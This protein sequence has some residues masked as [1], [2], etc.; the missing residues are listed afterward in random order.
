MKLSQNR[1]RN[2]VLGILLA[3]AGYGLCAC[4][5]GTI[6]PSDLPDGGAV[7]LPR[8]DAGVAR[9]QIP[10]PTGDTLM[11]NSN[12][13]ATSTTMRSYFNYAADTGSGGS[14]GIVTNA[15]ELDAKCSLSGKTLAECSDFSKTCIYAKCDI[16]SD[17][18]QLCH[19]DGNGTWKDSREVA[20]ALCTP[21]GQFAGWLCTLCRLN[22]HNVLVCVEG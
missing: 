3:L 22:T 18:T 6:E 19:A 11:V 16:S 4:D 9:C 12:G 15:S 1:I 5:G 13:V 7:T 2:L 21:D 20:A 17:G 14:W 10:S 8:T